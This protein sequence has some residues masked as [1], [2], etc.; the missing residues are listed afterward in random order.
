MR[1]AVP[2]LVLWLGAGAKVEVLI[3]ESVAAPDDIAQMINCRVWE[4]Y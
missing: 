3:K 2:I 1:K 4:Y